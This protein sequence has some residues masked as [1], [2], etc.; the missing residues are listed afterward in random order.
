MVAFS[1]RSVLM[2]CFHGVLA[3][4]ELR[5]VGQRLDTWRQRNIAHT[6]PEAE[7]DAADDEARRVGNAQ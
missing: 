2:G 5:L 7:D 4:A 1:A 3:D 6:G